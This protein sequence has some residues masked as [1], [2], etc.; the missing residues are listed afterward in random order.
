MDGLS[1]LSV[2]ASVAQ[3]IEFG[4]SLVSKSK[5]IYHST[6]GL[7]THHV[8]AAAA[9][10]RLANLSERIKISRQVERPGTRDSSADERALEAICDGCI[11][12]SKD[13]TSKLEKLKV[14][15]ARKHRKHK[16]FRQA[17]KSIWS[18]EAVNEIARRL[19]AF[20]T[21]LD[22]HL[23]VSLRQVSTSDKIHRALAANQGP[24]KSSTT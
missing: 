8:E 5:E 20:Q 22:V 17:L 3:F 13:L 6:N 2:A 23:L 14:D 19:R 12:V 16:S 10:T 15:D 4:S 1:A 7:P 24:V 11:T 9:A 21:E 18:K